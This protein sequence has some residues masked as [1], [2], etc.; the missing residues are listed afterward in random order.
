MET[1]FENLDF[2]CEN[3]T[4]EQHFIIALKDREVKNDSRWVLG[5]LT[6]QEAKKLLKYLEEHIE[7]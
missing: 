3:D 6:N 7:K 2:W 4:D 5:S 1:M